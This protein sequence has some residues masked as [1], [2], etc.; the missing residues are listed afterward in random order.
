[1][2]RPQKEPSHKTK[3]GK[4]VLRKQDGVP[5]ETSFSIH[6]LEKTKKEMCVEE[7]GGFMNRRFSTWMCMSMYMF[8]LS[9]HYCK[10]TKQ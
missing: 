6:L 7:K 4:K 8:S 10:K 5:S 3:Y 1:M 2:Y 9:Y